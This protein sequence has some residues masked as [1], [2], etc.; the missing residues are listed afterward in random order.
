MFST[1]EKTFLPHPLPQ[2]PSPQP[3][4]LGGCVETDEELCGRQ[5]GNNTQL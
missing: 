2:G 3:L 5:Y 4:D 1:E